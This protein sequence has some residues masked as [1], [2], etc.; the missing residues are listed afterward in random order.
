M[1]TIQMS[2][3][4]VGEDC[5]EA[6]PAVLAP[7]QAKTVVLVGGRRALAAAAPGIRAA[8]D[9]ANVQILDESSTAPIPPSPPSTRLLR[10]GHFAMPT[11]PSRSA[12]ARRSTR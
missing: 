5:F 12:G 1:R 2:S 4:T 6:I 9:S 3:Y 10:I 11:S 8:L 7:Y